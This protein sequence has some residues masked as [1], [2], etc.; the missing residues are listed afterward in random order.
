MKT[1][2]KI[3]EVLHVTESYTNPPPKN[4]FILWIICAFLPL[5]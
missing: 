2:Q 1:L 5:L 3:M 4:A